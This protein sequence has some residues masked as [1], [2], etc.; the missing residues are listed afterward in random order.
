MGKHGAFELNYSRDI[1]ISLLLRARGPGRRWPRASSPRASPTASPRRCRR[2]AAG[3][4]RRR[5]CLPRRPAAA[6]RPVVDAAGR[7]RA[8]RPS[9]TTRASARTGSGRPSSRPAPCAGD[10]AAGAAFLK[11]LKPFIWR[12]SLDYRRHRRH[13]FDQAPDPRPQDRRAAGGHGRQPE[14]GPRRHPRDRVLRPDPAADPGRPRPGAAQPAHPRRPRR[15][16]ATPAMSAP[17]PPPS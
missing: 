11:A 17:R 7:R 13:P 3:A 4:H 12:R 10:L 14:A 2:P 5:L 15:P 8:R 6:P 9:T 1:D 16:G